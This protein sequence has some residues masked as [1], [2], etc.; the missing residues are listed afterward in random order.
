MSNDNLG[1]PRRK[2]EVESE[3]LSHQSLK[4]ESNEGPFAHV[5]MKVLGYPSEDVGDLDGWSYRALENIVQDYFSDP[6]QILLHT[7]YKCDWQSK[8]LPKFIISEL[9]MFVA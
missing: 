2:K 1:T 4:N 7:M 3:D 9:R 5:T 8:E 6:A